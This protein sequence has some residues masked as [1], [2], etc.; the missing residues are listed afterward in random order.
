MGEKAAYEYL[1]GP[2]GLV[3][4]SIDNQTMET[5]YWVIDVPHAETG[6]TVAQG[7]HF[8]GSLQ[9]LQDDCE[10]RALQIAEDITF[11]RNE[12]EGRRFFYDDKLQERMLD[13]QEEEMAAAEAAGEEGV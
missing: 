13:A 5:G 7:D 8:S 12:L 11:L 4:I 1:R 9:L 10:K 3:R 6:S 2:N